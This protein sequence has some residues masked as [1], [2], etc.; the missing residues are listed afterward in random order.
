[1]TTNAQLD[2]D[3]ALRAPR[4][5][6]RPRVSW[7]ADAP[8]GSPMAVFLAEGDT[9]FEAADALCA[10]GF[11]VLAL[12]TAAF[13]VATIALEWA[14]DHAIHVGADA[15]R[16]VV[17]GGGLAA[18]VAL[19]ARDEGWPRLSRQVLIGPEETGWPPADA[20]LSGVA[21]ATVVDAPGYAARL[22]AAGVPV[23]ELRP[24]PATSFAWVRGLSN[25]DQEELEGV[26]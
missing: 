18:A 11:V 7:P 9:G 22:R 16:L 12:P 4:R 21:P 23:E 24:D 5:F 14:A 1:M 25:A 8:D 15:D 26:R 6:V 2:A 20:D 13:D 19:H 17:A 3:L 10:D